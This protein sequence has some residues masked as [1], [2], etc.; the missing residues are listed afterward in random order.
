MDYVKFMRT[1]SQEF[2]TYFSVAS[3]I[4]T[5][6]L[7]TGCEVLTIIGNEEAK[8]DMARRFDGIGDS[9]AH[10]RRI[11]IVAAGDALPAG[12]LFSVSLPDQITTSP[13]V[14]QLG[15]LVVNFHART[16][17]DERSYIAYTRVN[18]D[19]GQLQVYMHA[20]FYSPYARRPQ[21]HPPETEQPPLV[22]AKPGATLTNA[23]RAICEKRKIDVSAGSSASVPQPVTGPFPPEI[24]VSPEPQTALADPT[25]ALDTR[26]AD[27]LPKAGASWQYAYTMRGIRSARFNIGIRVAG[28]EGGIV[29]EIIT[30]PTSF[31]QTVSVSPNSLTFRSFLL[32]QSQTL[33]ELAPYLHTVL[34]K[35]ETRMWGNL[36]G[37]PAGNAI[38]PAWTMTVRESGQEEVTVPAGT[39]KATRIEV[40]GQRRMSSNTPFH[41]SY[42]SS[43]FRVR[44][45]YAPEVQRYVK[46]QHETWS[47]SGAPSGEQL[48]ELTSYSSQ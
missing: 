42:E 19:T 40:S 21:T 17:S 28:V 41:L 46:Q 13:D 45:W 16:A 7:L 18:C 12:E 5:S 48:V 30:T 33:V 3:L 22:I 35:N 36:A 34:A 1:N 37:Y 27:A 14:E 9:R 31:G 20:T 11:G 24:R 10:Y 26:P 39:F 29:R 44:A 4:C 6:L 15:I 8:A 25:R 47:L 23:A 43:R 38:L 32:A 2:A